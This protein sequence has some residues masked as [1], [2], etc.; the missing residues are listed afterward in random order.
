[1]WKQQ[2]PPSG[3]GAGP[4]AGPGAGLTGQYTL[5]VPVFVPSQPSGS[6]VG[7]TQRASLKLQKLPDSPQPG[8]SLSA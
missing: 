5:S 1:M 2:R 3:S 4:G 7:D 6:L 8:T